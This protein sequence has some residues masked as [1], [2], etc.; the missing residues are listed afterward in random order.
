MHAQAESMMT[1]FLVGCKREL[2]RGS[3]VILVR[4]FA[5]RRVR[6]DS[7]LTV[8]L[9]PP[10]DKVVSSILKRG[11]WRSG[12][13]REAQNVFATFNSQ[14]PTDTDV[15]RAEGEVPLSP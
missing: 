5:D 7:P 4:H 15:L 14:R 12:S 8:R 11:E 13:G 9:A 2:D 1:R 6:N 10:M 3:R